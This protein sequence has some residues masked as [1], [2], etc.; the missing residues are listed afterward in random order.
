[1]DSKRPNILKEIVTKI[2]S[3]WNLV[4]DKQV[5]SEKEKLLIIV[6]VVVMCNKISDEK[7]HDDR[8]SKNSTFSAHFH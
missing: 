7:N 1:M 2:V 3:V 4:M 6:F 5:L 8:V